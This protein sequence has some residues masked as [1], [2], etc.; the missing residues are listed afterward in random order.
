MHN[1][2]IR[3]KAVVLFLFSV[4]LMSA[5]SQVE[6]QADKPLLVGVRV[7]P[8]FVVRNADGSLSGLSIDL[9][10]RIADD[11]QLN[12]QLQEMSLPE[13]LHGLENKQIDVAVEAITVTDERE[14]QMD[15]THPFY[16]AGLGIAINAEQG[17]VSG[18]ILKEVFSALKAVFSVRLFHA[19][20]SLGLVLAI[21]GA[22]IWL[23]ERK[24]NPQQFGGS[25][26]RGLGSGFWWSAVTMTTVGYGDKAPVTRWGRLL[27]IIWMFASVIS[28]SGFTAAI[29]SAFTLQQI[30]SR[31]QGPQDLPGN[32]VGTVGGS[33]G[34]QF[35]QKNNLRQQIY[36]SPA[37]AVKALGEAKVN[38]VVYDQPILRYLAKDEPA[39]KV[40]VLPK[41]FERQ[42][43]AFGLPAGS[44]LREPINI[45]LLAHIR[46]ENW[47][48]TLRQ[49]L[50]D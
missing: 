33:T 23:F 47:Q 11:L 3:R 4:L 43:Y 44:D 22:L 45:S 26:I 2:P 7:A 18:N 15:F 14:A 42:D 40:N 32:L 10:K 29:A 50:G 17:K 37:T 8:P 20:L 41:S 19:L 36:D 28:I 31:I 12:Y 9:W 48:Q 5:I 49:Y 6:A 27:G 46:S 24:A 30:Q 39:G 25:P 16:S 35:I 21:I 38:T 1:L 13:L 34:A